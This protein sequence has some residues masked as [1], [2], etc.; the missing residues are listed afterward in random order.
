MEKLINNI[1]AQKRRNA[2]EEV[3]K[4]ESEHKEDA[5]DDQPHQQPY[6]QYTLDNV[7]G[8]EP[9]GEPGLAY[10]LGNWYVFLCALS[11]T[12]GG[13]LFG[14]DQGVVSITLVM[15]QFLTDIPDIATGHA[16]AGFKKGL[17][18]AL[19]ELGA[20]IGAWNQGWI[21]D[22]YSRKRSIVFALLIFIVGGSL[23]AAAQDYAMLTVARFI[24]GL[25]IGMLSMVAPLYISEISPPEIRGFLL[26]TE[27]FAV[28]VGVIVAYWLTFGT[29]YMSGEWAWRLPFLLQL[30]P[31][32]CLLAAVS[33]LPYSPRWLASVGRYDET[34]AT[35]C[36]LRNLPDSDKR[37]RR[38]FLEIKGEALFQSTV[39]KER[40]AHLL[41]GSLKH[42]IELE[43]ASWIDCFRPGCWRRTHIGIGIM[44]F[45]QFCGINALIYY[46]P[47]LFENMNFNYDMQLIMSGVLN[48]LQGVGCIT[49]FFTMETVGRRPL[50]LYGSLV[51]AGA[52]TIIAI[53]VGLYSDDWSAHKTE[54]WVSVAFLFIFM[55][56]Y[57]CSWSPVPWAL[58]A[59]I[60]PSS[61]RAKGVALT[62]CSNWI[63][64]FIIGLIT[65][66]LIDGTGFGTYVFFGAFALLSFFWT[67]FFVPETKG[68][69]LEM[70][71]TLFKDHSELHD[72]EVKMSIELELVKEELEKMGSIS[73]KV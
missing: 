50:L 43:L 59:E 64:N 67:Y 44:F 8:N 61:L 3:F 6:S 32:L 28:V 69:T 23:Q 11:S 7:F 27:S 48:S 40:H 2:P 71:D 20:F 29:R 55:L 33:F 47:T 21:A 52:H 68:V 30:V 62:T 53:M 24:G 56:G 70:M 41:D 31:C 15:D 58:P 38:E 35:L 57:A 1:S 10:I 42:S 34:L 45:Q 9:Y 22:K 72:K 19:L 17:M 46:S 49:S 39:T 26:V 63:N 5:S 4:F 18:T 25:G 60:F 13:F 51:M 37:I 66:P 16:G 54:A 12:V 14:Y 73:N 36:K 65:P